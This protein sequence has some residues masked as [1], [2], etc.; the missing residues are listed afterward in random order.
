M[1][2]RRPVWLDLRDDLPSSPLVGSEGCDVVTV[3][4]G[5]TGVTAALLLQRRGLDVVLLEADIIGAG[6]TGGTTGKLTSQHGLTYQTLVDRHG[7]ETA[8]AYADANQGA[9]RLVE[10][11]DA[12]T[13]SDSGF[14][15]ASAIVYDRDGTDVDRLRKEYEAA[16][17]L[18]LPAH[19]ISDAGL[20][21]EV[22]L[23]LE[24]RDQ[25][26]FHPVRYCRALVAEFKQNGGRLYEGT[27]AVGLDESDDQVEIE[28]DGGKVVAEYAIIAT[29]LPFVDR[30]GFFAKTKP[31]RAYGIAARFRTPPPT[32]MY[33]SSSG[34][35]RSLRPWPEGGPTGAIIVGET[36]STGDEDASPGRWGDLER[37]ANENFD[38]ES[39][40]YR[41]S[42]QDYYTADGVPY[43][44][45]SPLTERTF[46]ATGFA[47]WGLTNGTAAAAILTDLVM[48]KPNL[49]AEHFDAGRIGDAK[50]V[51]EL[52]KTNT[53]TAI[54]FARDRL[55]RVSLSDAGDLEPGQAG[56]VSVDGS[57]AAVYRD[58][59]GEMHGLSPT[60]TH[61]RC[62][63]QWNDAENTWDCPCHGSRFDID[64]KVLSGPATEPLPTVQIG[65]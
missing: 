6:T 37:W 1:S 43:I 26:Y 30:G 32:N 39:F 21:F 55:S 3:G 48:G 35:V 7:W 51:A 2:Q 36:H 31:S 24:F 63:V 47:K 60:C 42:A 22:S 46:V 17:D 59:S 38:V 25:A 9:L 44:G 34:P 4:G 11:L 61:L 56:I 50:A 20:P 64:G 57:A 33:I 16:K 54:A 27:R 52:V 65:R 23:A 8:Q 18:G 40:E 15:K 28:T 58:P 13:G 19:L 41:W 29:L 5:I 14:T 53:A 49:L 45:R 62:G 10:S 12:E